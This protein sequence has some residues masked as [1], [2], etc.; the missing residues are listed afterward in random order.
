MNS[1]R[2]LSESLDNAELLKNLHYIIDEH[3]LPIRSKDDLNDQIIE[4]EKYLGQSEFSHLNTKRKK[5]N[6]GTGILAL[7]ILIYCLFLFGSRYANN[8]GFNINAAEFNHTLLMGVI[9]YLWVVIIYALVF[10]SFIAYFYKLNKQTNE[11][12]YSIANKLFSRLN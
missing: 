5:A 2:V 7:P 9:N 4:I 11:E 10:V 12:M 8:F 1:L 6:I 3:H